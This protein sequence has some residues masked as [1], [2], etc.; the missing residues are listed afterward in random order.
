MNEIEFSVSDAFI[1]HLIHVFMIIN[2]CFMFKVQ[3]VH[4]RAPATRASRS[5]SHASL[6]LSLRAAFP[7]VFPAAPPQPRY[8]QSCVTL[9]D[10]D[11]PPGVCQA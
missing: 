10:L 9:E 8:K 6:P 1:V 3:Y 2:R 4:T 7:S 11:R 5:V